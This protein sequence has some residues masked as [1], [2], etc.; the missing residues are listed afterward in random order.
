M[1]TVYNFGALDSGAQSL[2]A[3]YT[4]LQA[5]IADLEAACAPMLAIWQG[6]ARDAYER[7][8]K[9][10]QQVG[11]DVGV[12]VNAVKD[13]VISANELGQMAEMAN[14]NRFMV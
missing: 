14:R 4:Q 7:L 5:N 10:W 6:E 12:F 3:T 1:K 2:Q 9:V 13:G 11:A 8:Q